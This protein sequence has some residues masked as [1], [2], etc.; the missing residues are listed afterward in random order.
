MNLGRSVWEK[1]G[2]NR[3]ATYRAVINQVY[4]VLPVGWGWWKQ[5]LSHAYGAS[6]LRL[7]TKPAYEV[8]LQT[9]IWPSYG[10]SGAKPTE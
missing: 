2:T 10:A 9:R 5:Q 6:L 1:A 7:S 3:Q 8:C 4:F